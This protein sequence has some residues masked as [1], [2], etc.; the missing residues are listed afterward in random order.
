MRLNEP[1]IPTPYIGGAYDGR[2]NGF[3]LGVEGLCEALSLRI[4]VP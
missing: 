2:V 4:G 1:I 3:F